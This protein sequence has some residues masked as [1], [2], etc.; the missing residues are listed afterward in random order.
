MPT[1]RLCRIVP[2][3]RSLAFAHPSTNMAEQIP[4]RAFLVASRYLRDP[5]F[6]QSVVLMIHHNERARWAW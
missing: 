2:L 1:M 3:Q 6:V 5:N 4:H